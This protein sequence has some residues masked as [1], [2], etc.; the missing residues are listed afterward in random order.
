MQVTWEFT[1][2]NKLFCFLFWCS[3][4]SFLYV[5]LTAQ[6]ASRRIQNYTHTPYFLVTVFKYSYG[7]TEDLQNTEMY[8]TDNKDAVKAFWMLICVVL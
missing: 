1:V 6:K 4:I 8:K 5:T 3:V 7:N 2:N